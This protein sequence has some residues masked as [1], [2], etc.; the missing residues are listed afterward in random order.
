[1]LMQIVAGSSAEGVGCGE[2]SV[3]VGNSGAVETAFVVENDLVDGGIRVLVTPGIDEVGLEENPTR[4][5]T[6]GVVRLVSRGGPMVMSLACL[7]WL[8]AMALQI[9]SQ[10][11]ERNFTLLILN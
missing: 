1:M 3:D 5:P 10:K 4:E 2:N 9:A 11:A 7:E 6:S 8:I